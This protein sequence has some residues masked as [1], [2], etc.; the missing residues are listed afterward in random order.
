MA[1]P[2]RREQVV[3]SAYQGEWEAQ[4]GGIDPLGL[5]EGFDIEREVDQ[6][7]ERAYRA[8]MTRFGLL[9]A[10]VFGQTVDAFTRGAL[11]VDE[12][13][14]R[15]LAIQGDTHQPACFQV[16]VFDAAFVLAKLLMVTALTC[17]VEERARTAIALVAVAVGM[18][19]L[20]GGVHT[21]SD[22]T[23]AGSHLHHAHRR[24]GHAG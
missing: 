16:D 17:W 8:D 12:L 20:V 15:T 18:P 19:E 5:L 14:E 1:H 3:R 4:Q 7:V 6:G 2:V 22:G 24:D 10:Q 13:V 21:Q 9:N 11:V 23:A